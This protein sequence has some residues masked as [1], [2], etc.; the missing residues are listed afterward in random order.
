MAHGKTL[1]VAL[2]TA[3]EKA[4]S[5][6]FDANVTTL[7]TA[8]ILFLT[9]T[10]PVKGF[11]IVLTLGILVSLFTALIVGRNCL[12]WLVDTQRL[13]RISMLHSA[14]TSIS[15]GK[16]LCVHVL[17]RSGDCP[18]RPLFISGVRKLS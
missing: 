10:G 5:S 14:Q 18:E 15:F 7:I 6:I 12:G 3:Y 1:N 8:F 2:K 16:A 13:K 9:A 17:T 4:F 11:A